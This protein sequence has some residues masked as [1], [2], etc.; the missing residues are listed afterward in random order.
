MILFFGEVD[1]I[2]KDVCIDLFLLGSVED[3]EGLKL[4]MLEM[5]KFFFWGKELFLEI[6]VLWFLLVF[7]DE[8]F[9]EVEK[10]I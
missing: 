7:N 2:V 1:E 8:N 3:E 6:C 10:G 4:W 9:W 5:G